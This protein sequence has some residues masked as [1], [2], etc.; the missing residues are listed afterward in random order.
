M[1][2]QKALQI[3]QSVLL[4]I[5]GILIACS[6]I[7]SN[8]LNYI[9]AGAL[10][11]Y[12]IFLLFKAIFEDGT[13]IYL[14][15]IVSAILIGLSVSIFASYIN[16]I[17]ILTQ[18]ITVSVYSIGG[19]IFVSGIVSLCQKKL[20]IGITKVIIGAILLAIGLVL[21]LIPDVNSYTWCVFGILLALFGLYE[22]IMCF[23]K[24]SV[25]KKIK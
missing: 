20:N 6:L 21:I 16:A 5:V 23:V 10:L 9:L 25:A 19:M 7:N 11:I 22:L 17:S 18:V 24:K 2:K 8:I 12:A 14:N 13:L 4:I 3:T 1:S 15:G